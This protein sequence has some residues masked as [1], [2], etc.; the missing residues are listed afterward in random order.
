MPVTLGER[1]RLEHAH[2]IG[3]TGGGKTT[4][5]EHC[6]RQDILAGRGVAVVDPHGDHPDSVYRRLLAWI[7]EK[8][9]AAN[10]VVH[11]IDPNAPTHTVGFNPLERPD[12]ETDLSVITATTLEAFERVW[13]D[14]DTHSKPTIRRVLTATFTALA[15]RGL[16]LAEAELLFDPHDRNGVRE[17]LVGVLKDRYARNVLSELHQIGLDDRSKRDFRTEIVGPINRI[18]EFVRSSAIRNILGQTQN[19]IDLRAALDEGHIILANLSGGQRVYEADAELLGRLLTR[20]LFF[21]AK[22]RRHPERPF[23]FYLDE[24]QRYLS[25]D[26]ETMLAEVRKFGVGVV[27]SHQWLSQL[28]APDEP[29][30]E[31]VLNATNFKAVFRV[32]SP[33][34]AEDLATAVIPL[35]L[36]TPVAVLN[37]PTVVGNRRTLFR[38][39]GV[40]KHEARST[41]VGREFLRG[42]E[43][44]PLRK[45]ER[46]HLRG[47]GD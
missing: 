8:G 44:E 10:R 18:A 22:R 13:G 9:I 26:V 2:V 43:R 4:F 32:K 45:R 36:E 11:L 27:L 6:I 15:E 5:L 28:G 7:S 31:A 47:R 23:F 34:E 29:M 39:R 1:P 46:Q 21:H 37:K 41:A 12:A 20:F 19:T 40:A 30:R 24:C 33:K 17:Y 25:G 3:T 42:R 38:S 14:E 16:T 35:N